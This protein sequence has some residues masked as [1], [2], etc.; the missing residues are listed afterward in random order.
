MMIPP[1]VSRFVAGEDVDGVVEYATAQF[2]STGIRPIVNLLGE[3]YTTEDAVIS[4]VETYISVA[5]ALGESK[6]VDPCI[7]VKPSQLGM[8]ITNALF[9][10]SVET[11][12][13]RTDVRVWVDMESYDSYADTISIVK[14]LVQKYPGR[15]GL[16]LQAN[17]KETP[18][19]IALLAG[20]DMKVRLVKGA[21]NEY[22]SVAYQ[23]DDAV[24]SA[25]RSCIK[26]AV[27]E[28]DQ[29]PT[30]LA[31][32]SHHDAMIQ[33]AYK[34]Q[35]SYSVSDFEVQMLM[36]VRSE[37]QEQL[38]GYVSMYQ[39]IP[40]GSKWLSYFYRR[41]RENKSNIRFMFRALIGR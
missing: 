6:I 19:V 7:S 4:D 30:G 10:E 36:G 37:R 14:R 38:A 31:V 16:C 33:L 18:E 41:I 12:V 21:Y 8:D 23:S 26:T 27:V 3:Q 5:N 1:I 40:F 34:Y 25:Y 9:A 32:G 24:D 28:F 29:T 11:I 39:Y 20:L 17:I 35:Q 2:E 22:P 13:S 15:L